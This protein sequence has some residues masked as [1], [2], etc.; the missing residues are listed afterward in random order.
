MK[1]LLRDAGFKE[2][3]PVDHIMQKSKNNARSHKHAHTITKQMIADMLSGQGERCFYSGLKFDYSSRKN[4]P[5][6]PSVDRVD[7]TRGYVE[8]NVVLTTWFMNRAK[9][10]CTHEEFDILLANLRAVSAAYLEEVRRAGPFP[11]RPPVASP[12][13]AAGHLD[14]SSSKDLEEA[15]A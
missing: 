3:N 5:L 4:N 6:Y 12:E 7:S 13:G 8:G 15:A 11:G 1:R 2:K 10:N 9:S 14:P